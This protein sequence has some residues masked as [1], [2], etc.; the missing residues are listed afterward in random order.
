MRWEMR[1]AALVSAPSFP[2]SR[3][4]IPAKAG[5]KPAIRNQ[6]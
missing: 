3:A 5:I 4:V 2:P 6:V 1:A